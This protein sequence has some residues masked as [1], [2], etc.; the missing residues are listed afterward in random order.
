[1]L[2]VLD[3][4]ELLRRLTFGSEKEELGPCGN[5]R[6]EVRAA[7]SR[8]GVENFYLSK[9]SGAWWEYWGQ[10]ESSGTA[11][12]RGQLPSEWVPLGRFALCGSPTAE[13]S[14]AWYKQEHFPLLEC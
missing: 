10:R 6:F 13:F 1:M 9:P 3:A 14:S 11:G 4:F 12:R 7:A 5:V 8:Y 2:E